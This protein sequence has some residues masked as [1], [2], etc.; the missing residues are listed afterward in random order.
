LIA[1]ESH[2]V[3]NSKTQF[4]KHVQTLAKIAEHVVLLSGSP[5]MNRPVELYTQLSLVWPDNS[6]SKSEYEKRYCDGHVDNFGKW[7]VSGAT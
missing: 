2:N 3:K 6:L 5:A 1:D 4:F 7:D